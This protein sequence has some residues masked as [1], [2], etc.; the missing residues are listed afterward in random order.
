MIIALLNDKLYKVSSMVNG[1]LGAFHET[2]I[3]HQ[4]MAPS[5]HSF[6]SAAQNK[7]CFLRGKNGTYFEQGIEKKKK[8]QQKRLCH[9]RWWEE[10]KWGTFAWKSPRWSAFMMVLVHEICAS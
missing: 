2:T 9:A 4:Y 7:G 6:F 1:C 5:G 3:W 8:Q 10:L